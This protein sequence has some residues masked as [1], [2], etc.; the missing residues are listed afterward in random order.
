MVV[1]CE[2][3]A[4]SLMAYRATLECKKREAVKGVFA[5]L[6]QELQ[7]LMRR[8]RSPGMTNQS[9]DVESRKKLVKAHAGGFF[10]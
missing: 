5:T 6:P 3:L 1:F 9:Y 4:T 10:R 7:L 8:A 2:E